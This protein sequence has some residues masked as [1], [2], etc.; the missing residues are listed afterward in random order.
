MYTLGQEIN[1]LYYILD[2]TGVLL[3]GIIGGTIARNKN[4]DIIGFSFLALFSA[5]AGGMMRDMLMQKGTAA[6]IADPIYLVMA[7]LGG[8]IALIF[9]PRGKKWDWFRING[10][11]VVLGVWSVTGSLKALSFGMPW[12]SCIFMGLITAVGGG[13]VRDISAG[14]I[15]SIFGGNYLYATPAI[16]GASIM[17]T[18]Y[19]LN[20]VLVGMLLATTVAASMVIIGYRFE[21]KLPLHSLDR[22]V[23]VTMQNLKEY[24]QKKLLHKKDK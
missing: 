8:L 4:F 16:V 5:L 9:Y 24:I 1:T 6:A 18:F 20:Y 21:V 17:V 12:I 23:N 11:A 15:P 13:M 10:D 3:N 19:Y 7:I 2:L 22:P 14:M